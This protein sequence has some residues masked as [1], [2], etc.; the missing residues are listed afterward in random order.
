[1]ATF[2]AFGSE[3]AFRTLRPPPP[4][5]SSTGKK[6]IG[7]LGAAASV[8]APSALHPSPRRSAAAASGPVKTM[9]PLPLQ[10]IGLAPVPESCLQ[11]DARPAPAL[12]EVSRGRAGWVEINLSIYVHLVVHE[13]GLWLL[14]LCRYVVCSSLFSPEI[15]IHVTSTSSLLPC[16]VHS[17]W[18]FRCGL[19]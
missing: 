11:L 18:C 2:S 12:E 14:R 7:I 10:Q 3:V 9:P 5:Y 1:M 6:L 8:A 17:S 19:S 16:N 13:V 4:V 15:G